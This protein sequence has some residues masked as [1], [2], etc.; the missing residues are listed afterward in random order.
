MMGY[1]NYGMMGP[2]F[3]WGG[4]IISLI[5]WILAIFVI[6]S[7]IRWAVRGGHNRH[8]M[9][10]NSAVDILKERYAKGEINKQEFDEKMKDLMK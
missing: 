4:G 9:E 3:G 5:F 10:H 2:W 7:L 1:Y 8:W 6:I